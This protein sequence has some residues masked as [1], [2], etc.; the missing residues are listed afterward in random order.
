M[1][2]VVYQGVA[3]MCGRCPGVK[4]RGRSWQTHLP[5]V[6]QGRYSPAKIY[7]QVFIEP[8]VVHSEVVA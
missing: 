6:T 2:S 8:L 4:R 3:P 7:T 1:S 5:K